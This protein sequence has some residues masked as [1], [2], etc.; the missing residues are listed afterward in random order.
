MSR[1]ALWRQESNVKEREQKAQETFLSAVEEGRVR[2]K[3]CWHWLLNE[4]ALFLSNSFLSSINR[5]TDLV[6]LFLCMAQTIRSTWIR[7]YCKTLRSLLTLRSAAVSLIGTP[8]SMKSITKSSMLSH[9]VQVRYFILEIRVAVAVFSFIFFD[10][11]NTS[12]VIVLTSLFRILIL[13]RWVNITVS[14]VWCTLFSWCSGLHAAQDRFANRK[15]NL[16]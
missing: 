6:D 4:H 16:L 12:H 15:V 9:G 14:I 8:W 2:P 10:P 1:S 3:C 7:C 5:T 13:L 11:R